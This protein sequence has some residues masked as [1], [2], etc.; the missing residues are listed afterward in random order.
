MRRPA[1]EQA[2]SLEELLPV[3]FDAD[4]KPPPARPSKNAPVAQQV[5]QWL[6]ALNEDERRLF[7]S[8]LLEGRTLADIARELGITRQAVSKRWLRSLNKL[9]P[10]LTDDVN[11]RV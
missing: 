3:E 2:A 5:S 11:S 10:L 4:P 6:D 9:R 1:E 8:H 7:V